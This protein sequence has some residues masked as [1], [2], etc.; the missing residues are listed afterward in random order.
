MGA[1]IIKGHHNFLDP[2]TEEMTFFF[3]II[4]ALDGDNP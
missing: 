2:V 1:I 4:Y 3:A